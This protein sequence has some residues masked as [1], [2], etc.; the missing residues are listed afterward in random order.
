[1]NAISVP[2]VT[3]C[4]ITLPPPI[5]KITATVMELSAST[6]ENWRGLVNVGHHLHVARTQ[7]ERVELA[8]AF[9]F[10]REELHDHHA[11]QR[12]RQV[13]VQ[14][15][16]TIAYLAV[17]DARSGTQEINYQRQRRNRAQGRQRQPRTQGEHD[18]HD[19]QQRHRV[20]EYRQRAGR[21]HIVDRIDI[22]RH[23]ADQP[24]RPACDRRTTSANARPCGTAPSADRRG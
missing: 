7:V 19:A 5:H 17:H 24:C 13:R 18:R 22:G 16:E 8:A 2:N 11:G 20:D 9:A 10:A 4:R 6:D 15:G 14:R 3:R 1:M 23:S 21:E 12:F